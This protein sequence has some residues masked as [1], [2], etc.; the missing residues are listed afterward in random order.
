MLFSLKFNV[1]LNN[2]PKI[3]ELK[4]ACNE[5]LPPIQRCEATV[6]NDGIPSD[7]ETTALIN[8]QT[9]IS[10]LNTTRFILQIISL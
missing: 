10:S 8:I 2:K 1:Y 6:G 4:R 5:N 3:T 9:I 7:Y